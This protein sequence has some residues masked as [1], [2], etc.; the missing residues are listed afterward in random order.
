MPLLLQIQDDI[1][2]CMVG[3]KPDLVA[4]NYY[5]EEFCAG[6]DEMDL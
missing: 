2:E 4:V 1:V 6:S 3:Q 5:G